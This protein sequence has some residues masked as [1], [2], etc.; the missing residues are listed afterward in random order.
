MIITLVKNNVELILCDGATRE[1]GKSAGPR[2]MVYT[3]Q[4]ERQVAKFLGAVN[5]RAFPRG[6]GLDQFTFGVTRLFASVDYAFAWMFAHRLALPRDTSSDDPLTLELFAA[7]QTWR[8]LHPD[9]QIRSMKAIGLSVEVD[10]DIA[11]GPLVDSTVGAN[12]GDGT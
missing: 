7:G 9:V 2:G 4:E 11:G 6:N 5:A 10:Y 8:L 3:G 1:V 12:T